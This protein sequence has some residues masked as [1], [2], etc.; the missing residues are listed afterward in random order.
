[1]K[2]GSGSPLHHGIDIGLVD[3]AP[4]PFGTG[5]IFVGR[6]RALIGMITADECATASRRLDNDLG[7]IDMAGDDIGTLIDQCVGGFRLLDR[8]RPLAGEDR[9][10][11]D[12]GIDG[13]RAEQEGVDVEQHLGDRLGSDEADLLA[14]R[15]VAGGDAIQVLPHA[16]VAEIGPR[17]HRMLVLV[18]H[19]A[20]MAELH[21]R[22]LGAHRQHVGGTGSMR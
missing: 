21:G 1:M 7:T 4:G 22:E 19:A 18:P 10:T 17:I 2:F 20:A 13:A 9:L 15:R 3:I 8:Q 14:L 5:Q 6:Q 12:G 16:D 11:G